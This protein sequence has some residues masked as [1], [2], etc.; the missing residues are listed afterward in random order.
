MDEFAGLIL[1]LMNIYIKIY[2]P[3]LYFHFTKK[4]VL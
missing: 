1:L 4:N 2:I 3:K